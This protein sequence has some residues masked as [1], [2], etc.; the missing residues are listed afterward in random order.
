M[1]TIRPWLVSR[2]PDTGD[3]WTACLDDTTLDVVHEPSIT[4]RVEQPVDVAPDS[5]IYL[6]LTQNGAN[7]QPLQEA[8][9]RFSQAAL[10]ALVSDN[11]EGTIALEAG[12]DDYLIPAETDS[13]LFARATR[14]A[15]EKQ[16]MRAQDREAEFR[17][18]LENA[19]DVIFV[20]DLHDQS[21]TYFNRERLFG[22]SAETLAR[23]GAMLQLI[24]DDDHAAALQHWQQLSAARPGDVFIF[25]YRLRPKD[26]DWEWVQS[27][28]TV[29]FSAD[30][31]SARQILISLSVITNRRERE[32]A[33]RRYAERL[34][35]LH[36]IDQAIV[37]ARS[38]QT[39]AQATLRH[40]T[41]L[42]TCRRASVAIFNWEQE[43]FT[44]VAELPEGSMG[45]NEA[46]S[47]PLDWFWAID[48]LKQGELYRADDITQI[49][50]ENRTEFL[51]WLESQGVRSLISVPLLAQRKLIGALSF[52][53]GSI[54]S[55][56]PEDVVV[57]REVAHVL[58]IGI[59][60]ARLY[61]QAHYHAR[62][63][64]QRARR[65]LLVS[66]LSLGVNR[67]VDLNAVLEEAARGLVQVI[68]LRQVG[69]VL[70]DES[71]NYWSHLVSH[72]MRRGGSSQELKIKVQDV[73]RL[74]R[75]LHND[76][77]V[78]LDDVRRELRLAG[79]DDLLLEH[80]LDSLMIV[81]LQV[82]D[83]VIG[84]IG[85][86]LGPGAR[87]LSREETDLVQTIANLV[88]IK[89]E[90]IRLLDAERRAREETRRQLEEL[91]VLHGL[92]TA[93]AEAKSEDALLARATELMKESLFP[94]NF[95][96]LLYD[97]DEKAL[98][99][100]H[101][102]QSGHHEQRAI[103]IPLGVGVCGYVA[104]SGQPLRLG[105]VR[106]DDR[107]VEADPS[108]LSELCV[109]LKTGARLLGVV[110]VESARPNAYSDL[111]ERLLSTFAHQLATAI[112]KLRL[113]ERTQA[114]LAETQALYEISRSLI[115]AQ[116]LPALLQAVVNGV[117][118]ALPA[119]RTV[120]ITTD[121]QTQQVIDYVLDDLGYLDMPPV[122]FDDLWEG[123]S[124]WVLREQQPLLS[125]KGQRDARESDTMHER[126]LRAGA[127][128]IIVVPL[129][130]RD[131]TLGTIT[132]VNRAEA[133]DFTQRN[134]ELMTAMANQAAVA[135]ENAR[136]FAE[137]RRRAEELEVLGNLSAALRVAEG[138]DE[139]IASLLKAS[140]DLFSADVVA[141]MVPGEAPGTL[142]LAHGHGI[143]DD[144][145]PVV[146][147]I[148]SSIAGHVFTSGQPYH[149][150]HILED[151]RAHRKVQ[152]AWRRQPIQAQTAIYA[153]LQAGR[154]VTGVV[155]V[156]NTPQHA[157]EK[158]DLGL[159]T[160][161]AEITGSALHRA[162]LMETLEQRVEERTRELA[163]ANEQLKVLDRLKSKF[164]SDV[165]HE[166]RTPITSLSLYLD[167]I[168]RAGPERSQHYWS[169]LRKQTE[170]LNH[171]IEDIL[172]LSRLQMGKI[173]VSLAPSD[174]NEIVAEVVDM[175]R[176]QFD[177][178]RLSL[179]LELDETL[180]PV[181]G[182]P[183]LLVQVINNLV[184]NALSY[185]PEGSVAVRTYVDASRDMACVAIVDSGV[186]ISD[187]DL[188]H[189]FERFYRGQ[190]TG[191]SNI[192]GTGLGLTIVEE[193]VGL[194]Y[195]RIDVNSEE[196]RGTT[197]CVYLPLA[198]QPVPAA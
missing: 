24:H 58:A 68:D 10:I 17:L 7:G 158:E 176:D 184:G 125:P 65:L 144:M 78:V 6:D 38:P 56:S 114:N 12:A 44:I 25:E 61:E 18:Y 180:P 80:R 27:R 162:G 34:Q 15:R 173:D 82:R 130:Y 164:V 192:P 175:R 47:L 92:A 169:V 74:Q 122:S 19:P 166:L 135:I 53:A 48:H 126:R 187:D 99:R 28:E 185:T 103:H 150:E 13:A 109:P 89:V 41:R 110:N 163:E 113:F 5:I 183:D 134:V 26:G 115:A 196:G 118:Q 174:L 77:P 57:M 60:Q 73:A 106:Q 22:Y 145:T 117:A 23:P 93:G 124:G 193:I 127:G 52:G 148:E 3:W 69:I 88:A 20:L 151:P 40:I 186:G 112:E 62:K 85:C 160:A 71:R 120:L 143:P 76:R 131:K 133:P 91:K 191:Q 79:L 70:L 177:E 104:Q 152:A 155:C 172:S 121:L 181:N 8:R 84:V 170:R 195:G 139:I 95:G 86:D 83:K 46:A 29:L 33:V 59:S 179:S 37:A 16:Q 96:V 45:H 105:D 30:E 87:P 119:D 153:P 188:P 142:A 51:R 101:T 64:E 138:A 149:S 9:R 4:E 21:I 98:Y 107:Y 141:I 100:H 2:S 167:L 137:T 129:R 42:V 102:Y 67:P 189:I 31:S 197:F 147:E 55:F 171:L 36:E 108:T 81:P 49:E 161:M 116:D 35:I 94:D 140:V 159:L 11:Q 123:L 111:Q 182:Q 72:S 165:S 50:P 66:D 32:A 178:A 128:A 14:H 156:M 1:I 198:P 190:A 63:L 97:E 54:A 39:I 75:L 168:E 132:A 154:R 136:L 157:L 43:T 90:H 146:Y 194:H